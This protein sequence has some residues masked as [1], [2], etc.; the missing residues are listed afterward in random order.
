MCN[1]CENHDKVSSLFL[2]E[3]IF[4]ELYNWI[5]VVDK[6]GYIVVMNKPYA[7]FLE[8]DHK[9]VIGKHVTD[10]IEN[11]RMHIVVKTGKKEIGQVQ[12]IKNNQMIADR[13]PFFQDGELVGAVGTVVFKNLLEFGMYVKNINKIEGEKEFYKEELRKV[14][15]S[16]FDFGKIIGNS[17][18]IKDVIVLS[19]KV[20]VYNSNILI[21]G[22]SGT[23]KEVFAR[24][25]H[26]ESLRASK[27]LIKVNCAAIPSGLLESELF[28][29]EY[30]AFTGS[31]KGGKIGK[32]ELAD[33]ST[34][35]LD[36][37]GDLPMDMQAKILRVIQEKEIEKVGGTKSQKI[38]VRII[39]ATNRDLEERV[40]EKAFREDLYYRLNVINIELPTLR[41]RKEDIPVLLRY[42]IKKFSKEM[43]CY[44]TDISP[45]A[46]D[47]LVKYD[48]P[49]N[50]RELSNVVERAMNLVDKEA[51]IMLRHLPFYITKNAKYINQLELGENTFLNKTLKQLYEGIEKEAIKQSLLHNDGNKYKTAKQ[52]DISRTSLY[53]KMSKYIME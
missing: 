40:K 39:A 2:Y 17:N 1:T 45:A 4:E 6:E 26:N 36:E 7:N 47:I 43:G 21:T 32:F 18:R 3:K 42:F 29:Y 44:V 24:A 38:D 46:L 51:T 31:K 23:G 25:I 9:E 50:I 10:V 41:E 5:V 12:K 22:E 35:F 52:L 37:I 28:G 14:Q 16:K 8:V 11:T 19:K 20:A 33:K 53:K 15:R 34:I 30:G 48:W 49:G 13:I 27:P